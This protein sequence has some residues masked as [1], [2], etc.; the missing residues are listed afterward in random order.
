M[1][2]LAAVYFDRKKYAQARTLCERVLEAEPGDEAALLNL[3]NCQLRE[4]APEDALASY[5]KALQVRA[6]YAEA[7][8]NRGNALLA[9]KRPAEALA[10]YDAALAVN[11]RHAG[12]LNNRGNALLELLRPE[13][14]LASYDAA[15]AIRPRHA[16]AL[17]N[18]GDALRELKRH[19]EAIGSYEQLL[20]VAPDHDYARGYL[21]GAQLHCCDWAHYRAGIERVVADVKAGKRAVAPFNFLTLSDSPADQLACARIFTADRHAGLPAPVWRGERYRHDRIRVAYL[22]SDF[23][24]HAT[25]YLMAGLFEAHDRSR[26]EI[27][28]MSFSPD[29]EDWMRTRLKSAFDRFIDV[30]TSSD[31]D[32]AQLL[33]ALEIDI[34]VDLKGY[35]GENRAGIFRH[36]GAPVQAGYL[37]YP[38]TMGAEW[39]DY[40]IADRVVI[41]EEHRLHYTEKV[42]YLPDSYQVNDRQRPIADRVPVRRE[43]GLPERGLVFCCF[44]SNHK[45]SPPVFEVWMRV[46]DRVAGSVLWLLEGSDAAARNL[47]SEAG[48]RGVAPERLVFAPNIEVAEHLARQRQ[49]DLFL[50]TLPYNAHTTASDALWAGVPVLTCAGSTFAGRV[51][52]SLLNAIGLPELVTG[53]LAAYERKALELAADPHLLGAMRGRLA[54]N[55]TTHPLFD[56]DRF[57]RHLEAAYVAMHERAQRGEP[58]AGFAV[59]ALA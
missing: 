3:G 7:L 32:V 25:A 12:A 28:A 45:L 42:V 19:E 52:A 37:G 39:I 51:A 29:R 46:L 24:S 55:R 5:E 15:L 31:R 21:L 38:G 16:E 26:F 49:A 18:R 23:R 59:P 4:G 13:A 50:D 20:S 36:R 57:R 44:N 9:L 22:S 47:R 17:V 6:D 10:S 1:N 34:A 43:L 53:S 33:R 56:T 11:A 48:R 54:Q 27:T 8:S 40:L 41:P 58:P 14:A 2:N 30:G 35:T